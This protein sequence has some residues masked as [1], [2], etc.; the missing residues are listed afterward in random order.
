MET[1]QTAFIEDHHRADAL[2]EAARQAIGAGDWALAQEHFSAFRRGIE[3][4]MRVEETFLFPA[5]EGAPGN[6]D[7]PLTHILRKGHK[8]LRAFFEE[9][10][11]AILSQDAEE[12]LEVMG[13]VQ[14]I[15][16]QHD[17]KEENELYPAIDGLLQPQSAT[18]LSELAARAA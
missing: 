2:F 4:H 3:N 13:T 1:L 18:V 12:A 5:F 15:L 14:V 8:D 10:L 6:A 7:D 9:V 17:A 16:E 11:E